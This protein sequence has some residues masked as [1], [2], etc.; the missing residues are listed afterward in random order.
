MVEKCSTK[1]CRNEVDLVYLGKPLCQICYERIC[2]E[3]D[4]KINN[5]C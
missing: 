2:E 3:E 4:L 5:N 1:F